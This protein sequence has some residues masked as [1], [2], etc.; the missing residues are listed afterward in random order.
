[1]GL[2]DW[3]VACAFFGMALLSGA[4]PA[5]ACPGDECAASLAFEAYGPATAGKS[6]VLVVFL[7]GSVSAGGPADY[8]YG[9]ARRFSE[10]HPDVVSVALLAPGYY[11]RKGRRSDGSDAGR[12][13]SDDTEALIPAL[14]SLRARFRA[15]KL[16][17]LGHSK[18][19][20]NMGGVLGKKP[21]LIQGA[22]LVAGI[23]DT[24]ALAKDRNRPQNGVDGIKLVSRIPKST[25]IILVHGD[26]DRE[27][28]ISQSQMFE[29]QA[30]R[31]GL[32]VR[33]VTLAGVEHNFNGA[34]SSAAIDALD[35][36]VN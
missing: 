29:E 18:G 7:H 12:R 25:R 28:R 14:E 4:E 20:M 5:H 33:L 21:G 3:A 34:L 8:M 17:V 36:L 22:V 13:L 24:E 32:P 6:G 9:Y 19:A 1:M 2:R 10:A 11:D 30:R 26:A 31:A 35:R 23:Y 16:L 27:V 15:R